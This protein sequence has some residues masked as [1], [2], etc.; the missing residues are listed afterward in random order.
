MNDAEE[1]SALENFFS[2]IFLSELTVIFFFDLHS[3]DY[4]SLRDLYAV[5]VYT[6]VT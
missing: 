3:S 1:A 4:S 6:Y 2:F 5:V